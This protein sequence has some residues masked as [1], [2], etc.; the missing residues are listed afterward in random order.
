[1]VID[2]INSLRMKTLF[3]TSLVASLLSL[4][5]FGMVA[6][7]PNDTT[8]NGSTNQTLLEQ[9][10]A[11]ASSTGALVS[12]VTTSTVSAV[13]SAVNSPTGKTVA[14][15]I[16]EAV[17]DILR[18]VKSAGG[19][20]YS[21]SKTAITKSVDF[22]MEQ[23]PLVVSEFLRWRMA[24]RI[25]YSIVWLI[26]AAL[27]IY[28]ARRCRIRSEAADVPDNDSHKTDKG[29]YTGFKWLFRIVGAIIIMI[30]LATNGMTITKITVAPRVYLLEYV[31][32]TIHN[33]QK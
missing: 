31:V 27:L 24:E 14:T 13:S 21:A 4:S 17:I 2:L 12:N 29:D 10:K 9:A 20:I 32:D 26:P 1:M 18:G 19:E 22:T 16:N 7:P 23:A 11:I 6:L 5:A 3:I 28:F 8:N 33:A 30:V 25:I 15:N